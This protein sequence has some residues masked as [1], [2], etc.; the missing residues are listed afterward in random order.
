MLRQ[1]DLISYLPQF[2]QEYREIKQVM[3]G[4]TPEIQVLEDETEIIKNNQFILSC[5]LV[6]IKRFEQLL[7][8][9]PNADDTLDSRISR[10]LTRWNDSI[11]Y[12][13]RGLIDK[14]NIMCGEGNYTLL[15]NFNAYELE[16]IV[17]LP[18]SG[19]VEELDYML[20]YM[21]PAN[22]KVTSNN[23]LHHEAKGNVVL[24]GITIQT[25]YFNI[26]SK[27]NKEHVVTGYITSGSAI[28]TVIERTIN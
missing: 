6:G 25:S 28:T 1:V 2:V 4:E 9:T 21:I 8:I 10:V 20:S 14:L 17:C 24:G 16:L 7:S 27:M 26:T 15:P 23:L 11:P 13:Y 18:L 5:D 22:I 19:Q 3:I 12:T